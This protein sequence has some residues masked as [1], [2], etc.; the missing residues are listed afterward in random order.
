MVSPTVNMVEDV[1]L[2]RQGFGEPLG[3]DRWRINWRVYVR[4]ETPQG[5][6][7]P[8]SGEGVISPTRAE[9]KALIPIVK[10]NGYTEI[11]A[12]ELDFADDVASRDV[13]IARNVYALRSG[14]S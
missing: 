11:A 8:E 9:F 3:S 10:Y 2:I 14:K 7:Y 13:E 6:M 1:D 12:R 5:R 4:E